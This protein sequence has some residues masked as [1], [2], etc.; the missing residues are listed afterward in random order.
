MKEK[1]DSDKIETNEKIKELV[2]ARIDAQVPSNLKLFIGSF[3]GM[4]K[5]EM[6]EHVRNEDEIGKKIIQMH[7]NFM[8]ALVRGEVTSLINSVKV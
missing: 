1:P 2:L 5:E 6:M 7:I 8:R 4:N 3:G